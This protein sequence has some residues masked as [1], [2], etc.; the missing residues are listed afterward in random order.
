MS[1]HS[2]D[3]FGAAIAET[4]LRVIDEEHLTERAAQVGETLRQRLAVLCRAHPFLA[5]VRGRGLM[6]GLD[7]LDRDQQGTL[8]PMLSLALEAECLR[9]GVILGYSALSGALRLLPPLTLSDAELDDALAGLDAAATYLE[10]HGIELERYLPS[11]PGSLQLAAGFVAR[12]AQG[13]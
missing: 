3:P 2:F 8:D 13:Q 9:H 6:I 7:V 10:T 12:F 5:N 1:S 11:H 4:V